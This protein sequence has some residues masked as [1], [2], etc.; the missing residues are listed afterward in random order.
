M[1]NKYFF[2]VGALIF[3][4]CGG[5]NSGIPSQGKPVDGGTPAPIDDEPRPVTTSLSKI[6]QLI[7]GDTVAAD[8]TC[9]DCN[10]GLT[11]YLW[12]IDRNNDGIFGNTIEVDGKF[13]SDLSATTDSITIENIDVA[14]KV[15]LSVVTYSESGKYSAEEQYS[16]YARNA[17]NSYYPGRL[18]VA[19]LRND[20]TAFSWGSTSSNGL[21]LTNV[22]SVDTYLGGSNFAALKEDNTLIY[23]GLLNGTEPNAAGAAVSFGALSIWK[24]DGSV[25]TLGGS[26]FGGDSSAVASLLTSGVKEIVEN[27]YCFSALKDNGDVVFWGGFQCRVEGPAEGIVATDIQKI[28][29]TWSSIFA[30]IDSSGAVKSWGS[31]DDANTQ[32]KF[33]A[34]ESQVQSDM[35]TISATNNAFSVLKTNGQVVS[36][37][38]SGGGGDQTVPNDVTGDLTSGVVEVSATQGAFAARKSDGTIITWG[39]SGQGGNGGTLTNITQVVGNTR[40]FAAIKDDKTVVAWGSSFHGGTI[41]SDIASQ[42]IDVDTIY[43]APNGS[44]FAALTS[45]GKIVSWGRFKTEYDAI[46]SQVASDVVDVFSGSLSFTAIK[47]DGSIVVW[48]DASYGGDPTVPDDI[49]ASLVASDDILIET[50][51]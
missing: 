35:Q 4:G 37:G 38:L 25:V 17:V 7:V 48:G 29:R 13:I 33:A 31:I 45:S 46:A 51:L 34:V 16:V 32:V 28:Y 6:G 47:K 21:D 20:G 49:S 24:Q 12:Q 15:R 23:W 19:A 11:T 39:A 27:Q 1:N 9:D 36:W 50:S 30:G 44:G 18:S 2:L 22:K 3:S 5:E 8:Y 40:A 41:P 10:R 43:A 42:L 26:S 14:K